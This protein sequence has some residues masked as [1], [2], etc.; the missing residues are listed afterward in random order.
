MYL[1]LLKVIKQYVL[2]LSFMGAT[3][4]SANM[5]AAVIINN[6]VVNC[7][8]RNELGTYIDNITYLFTILRIEIS[9]TN[10][11]SLIL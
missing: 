11:F 7:R 9:K 8:P 3:F 1:L 6:D 5:P 2:G 10:Y 4:P